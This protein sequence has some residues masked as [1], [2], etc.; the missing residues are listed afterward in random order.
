[1]AMFNYFCPSCRKGT[2]HVIQFHLEEGEL[3]TISQVKCSKCS[4]PPFKV[5]HVTDRLPMYDSKIVTTAIEDKR[6]ERSEKV[7]AHC[8]TCKKKQWGRKQV[9]TENSS[10]EYCSFKCSQCNQIGTIEIRKDA[11]VQR[12]SFS[13]DVQLGHA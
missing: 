10:M 5:Q 12:E 1:M 8:D 4:A 2:P 11:S 9:L 7:F 13:D 6:K 3:M